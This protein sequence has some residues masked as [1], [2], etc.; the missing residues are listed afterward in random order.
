MNNVI[1][2]VAYLRT[3][4]EFPEEMHELTVEVNKSYVD[5]ANAVN[6]RTISIFPTNRPAINGESWFVRNNQRQQGLRQV[7]NIVAGA[8]PILIPH[9][10]NFTRIFGFTRIYGTFTN[11]TNWYPLPYVNEVAANNQISIVVNSTN[12]V[13]TSGAG[14]PPTISSGFVVLEWLSQV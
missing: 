7:Y 12:I 2:Q 10:I 13:I 6:N 3:T 14:T 11:G 5:I 9:G 8:S 1:N 4:R